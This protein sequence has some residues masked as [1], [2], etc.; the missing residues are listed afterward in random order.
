MY[1]NVCIKIIRHKLIFL[2][3]H[4]MNLSLQTSYVGQFQ[5]RAAF[6]TFATGTNS[7]NLKS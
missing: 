6:S 3:L 5:V 4:R 1:E 7:S 2:N